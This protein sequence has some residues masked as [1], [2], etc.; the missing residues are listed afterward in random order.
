MTRY[1]VHD[2]SGPLLRA[3]LVLRTAITPPGWC[4]G[5]PAILLVHQAACDGL[6]PQRPGGL[7][8]PTGRPPHRARQLA[9]SDGERARCER[10]TPHAMCMGRQGAQRPCDSVVLTCRALRAQRRLHPLLA[11]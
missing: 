6:T 10:Y 7:A 2:I 3:G 5:A 8:G 4:G 9:R 1:V 11:V